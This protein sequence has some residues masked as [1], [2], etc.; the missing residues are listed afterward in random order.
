MELYNHLLHCL[1]IKLDEQRGAIT[2]MDSK[3]L[4]ELA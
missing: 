2:N 4:N 3:L 1:D